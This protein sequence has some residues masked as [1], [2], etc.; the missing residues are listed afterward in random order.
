MFS[1]GIN[2]PLITHAAGDLVS[3]LGVTTR[4]LQDVNTIR[5][6]SNPSEFIT[7][8][9]NQILN[10]FDESVRKIYDKTGKLV[11]T[12]GDKRVTD[13]YTKKIKELTELGLPALQVKELA[14]RAAKAYFESELEI[15]EASMPGAYAKAYGTA[16]LKNNADA[17]K[18]NIGDAE[19]RQQWKREYKAKKKAKKAKKLAKA[20]R[21]I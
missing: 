10:M 8:R 11:D 9:Q 15:L 5:A 6:I 21:K 2:S 12:K 7:S 16:Q 17:A 3:D 13:I 1:T 4:A 20:S 19:M 14:T 18:S